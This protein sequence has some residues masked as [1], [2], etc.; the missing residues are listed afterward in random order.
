MLTKNCLYVIIFFIQ[1]Y[2]ELQ[3]KIIFNKLLW[4]NYLQHLQISIN[5]LEKVINQFI[6]QLR[7]V[8][9]AL[10]A[11]A[12][13]SGVNKPVMAHNLD[14]SSA[15]KIPQQTLVSQRI[16]TSPNQRNFNPMDLI[17]QDLK[18]LALVNA[19]YSFYPG[20]EKIR[21]IT[22][23]PNSSTAQILL[24]RAIPAENGKGLETMIGRTIFYISPQ[25]VKTLSDLANTEGG[26][27]QTTIELEATN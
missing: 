10:L 13:L 8:P 11:S 25:N 19:S 7:T 2:I 5:Y 9:L 3:F 17:M 16:D 14:K 4:K 21:T 26:V 24:N 6:N 15:V 22:F 1:F 12:S 18:N 27:L 20:T 23:Q